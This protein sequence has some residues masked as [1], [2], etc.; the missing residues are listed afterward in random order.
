MY[1]IIIAIVAAV[2]IIFTAGYLLGHYTGR[3]AGIKKAT[4]ISNKYK[5]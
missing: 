3:V 4:E 1:G 5:I 2:A